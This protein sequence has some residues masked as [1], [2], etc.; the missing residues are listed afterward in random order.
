MANNEVFLGSGATMTLVPELDFHIEPETTPA[1]AQTTVQLDTANQAHFRLVTNMYVGCTLELYNSSD[2]LQ[3]THTVTSN[4]ND[5]FTFTPALGGAGAY[6]TLKAYGA[7]CPA[8][9]TGSIAR[10]NA[11][12]WLGLVESATFPNLEVEM[13]Q[14]NLQIGGTRNYTYQYKGIETASGGNISLVSNHVGWLYY[15]LGRCTTLNPSADVDANPD[16]SNVHTMASGADDGKFLL[17]T[18]HIETGPFVY[19]IL[20]TGKIVPP[21]APADD[22]LT[23]IN[24]FTVPTSSEKIDYVFQEANNASLPSFSLEYTLSKLSSTNTY[25]TETG[26]ASESENFVRIAR[27]NRIN[28]LTLTANENEEVKMTLDLNTS[29]VTELPQGEAYEARRGVTDDANFMNRKSVDASHLEPFFFYDGT[30]KL[31]GNEF[32][33][34]TNLTLTMNNNIQDKRFI[35]VA[36]RGIKEGIPSQ[37]TYELSFTALVTDDQLYEE[38]LS[39]T[40]STAS[41]DISLTFTKGSNSNETFTLTFEDYFTSTNTWTVPDDKGVVTAEATLTPRTLNACSASSH[42]I[43]Q[44]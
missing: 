2:E 32:L 27:G 17:D 3:S 19:R 42:W 41:A 18:T 1:S 21:L 24:K 9:T 34:I 29:A 44:G 43:L 5:T 36:D 23:N 13:K 20:D 26:S 28:T 22:T 11:D 7:P 25:Q 33:K 12:I 31:Y 38:L 8:P 37:R 14:M 39:S 40:E 15:F 35:G 6:F 10:L 16:P 4:T 30:V